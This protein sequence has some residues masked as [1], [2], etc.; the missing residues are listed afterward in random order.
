MSQAAAALEGGL[1]ARRDAPVATG[2][3]TQLFI[4]QARQA[5]RLLHQRVTPAVCVL[6]HGRGQP[7][8]EAGLERLKELS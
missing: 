1:D 2:A 4:D 7:V 5:E 3:R 8:T 6:M